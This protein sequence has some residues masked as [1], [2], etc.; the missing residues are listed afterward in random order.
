MSDGTLTYDLFIRSG[1]GGT[2]NRSISQPTTNQIYGMRLMHQPSRTFRQLQLPQ[3]LKCSTRTVKHIGCSDLLRGRSVVLLVFI[4]FEI[5]EVV[6]HQ[7]PV[8]VA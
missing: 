5:D 6:P 3:C 7:Q 8:H 4:K 2:V 1:T